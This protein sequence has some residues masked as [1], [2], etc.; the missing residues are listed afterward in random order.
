MKIKFGVDRLN[1]SRKNL[2]GTV[3]EG[4]ERKGSILTGKQWIVV[5]E[6]KIKRPCSSVKA[7]REHLSVSQTEDRDRINK[8]VDGVVM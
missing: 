7:K 1:Y 3:R 4:S 2:G 8:C 5:A 6:N